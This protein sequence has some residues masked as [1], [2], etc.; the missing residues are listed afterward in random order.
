MATTE[1]QRD[2][3]IY[4]AL[5]FDE[6]KAIRAVNSGA[7]NVGWS[8]TLTHMAEHMRS[9]SDDTSD[10]MELGAA[11]H[12]ALL[13]PGRFRDEYDRLQD[14]DR[15]TKAGREAWEAVI[16]E[17]R[18]PL[19]AEDFD[20]VVVIVAGVMRNRCAAKVIGCPGLREASMV[21]RDDETGV[22]C[23][24][25]IDLYAP[26]VVIGDV[27]TTRSAARREFS[28][29]IAQRGYHRQAAMY[30][31]GYAKLSGEALDLTLIVVENA[32]PYCCAVY[33]LDEQ[34]I[35]LGR[36]EYRDVLRR[37]KA[38]AGAGTLYDGYGHELTAIGV[39]EWAVRSSIVA[40]AIDASEDLNNW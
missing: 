10:A 32:A 11:A 37:F 36:R 8:K 3:G 23:K 6:Y 35:E 26:G 22:L 7:V 33:H 13:E 17:G 24:G 30:V 38:S 20:A 28:R 2:T 9:P 21:W 12:C 39:P 19:H 1:R 16:A 40:D 5:P 34:A 29:T 18:K 15:R 14:C 4:P 27:K 25:R 31:D